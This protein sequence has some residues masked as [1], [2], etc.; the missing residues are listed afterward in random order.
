ME[1]SVT[2]LIE[3]VRRIPPVFKKFSSDIHQVDPLLRIASMYALLSSKTIQ[4]PLIL[5]IG[6]GYGTGPILLHSMGYTPIGI[7]SNK[8]KLEDG[9][10][11]WSRLGYSVAY[12]EDFPTVPDPSYVYFMNRHAGMLDD[13]A[14]SSLQTVSSFYI[15]SYM[16]SK[17]HGAFCDVKRILAD[18]GVF[19]LSTSDPLPSAFPNFAQDIAVH[20]LSKFLL[21]SGMKIQAFEKYDKEHIRDYYLFSLQKVT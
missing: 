3:S 1:R 20:V 7:E 10:T 12:V 11:Y 2:E 8:E 4:D 15:S 14:S 5:D 6:C 16:L 17:K 13:I 21:P 18:D 19:Y 9:L